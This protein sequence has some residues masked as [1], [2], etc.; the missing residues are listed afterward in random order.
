MTEKAVA[1]HSSTFAWKIPWKEEPGRLQSMGSLES[2][3]TERL[4]FHF[5]LSCIGEGN[6]N[7]LQCSC[8]ENPRDGGAWWA[9]FY[10]VAQSRTGLKRRS[11]SSSIAAWATG[12]CP[13]HPCHWL[14]WATV[15]QTGARPGAGGESFLISPILAASGLAGSFLLLLGKWTGRTVW[16][17]E[18]KQVRKFS[19]FLSTAVCASKTR[20]ERHPNPLRWKRPSFCR[21]QWWWWGWGRQEIKILG[22]S[23]PCLARCL[24]TPPLVKGKEQIKRKKVGGGGGRNRNTERPLLSPCLC[25]PHS[26]WFVPFVVLIICE[27]GITGVPSSPIISCIK[28]GTQ[29][30]L[31]IFELANMILKKKKHKKIH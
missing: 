26:N 21:S 1:P 22:G 18:E 17:M 19:F 14:A 28:K 13:Q 9:A 30:P 8:L 7:P 15:S 5:S 10:G 4:Y 16:N 31:I 25:A 24:W 3:T 12:I 11:S 29:K 6:G 2:D 27:S 20:L 23:V